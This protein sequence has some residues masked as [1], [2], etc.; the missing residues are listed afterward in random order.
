MKVRIIYSTTSGNTQIVIRQIEQSLDREGVLY[1]TSKAEEL[2]NL[3]LEQWEVL[4]LACG[5]YGHGVLQGRMRL[6]VE[7]KGG[8]ADLTGVDGAV[9]WL[10]DDKYDREYNIESATI[11]EQFIKDRWGKLLLP[12]LRINKDPLIQ[13][14]TK[15]QT[16]IESFIHHIHS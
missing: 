15:I 16:W 11:L 7:R 14:D 5:T 12:S 13:V 1:R 3:D 4:V 2:E 9:V 10:G 6:F 8:E